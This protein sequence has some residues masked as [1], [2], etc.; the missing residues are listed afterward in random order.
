[1]AALRLTISRQE[2]TH[3][4]KRLQARTNSTAS[5]RDQNT[6]S[7]SDLPSPN[8]RCVAAYAVSAGWAEPVRSKDLDGLTMAS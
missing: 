1:M 6:T 3:P 8:W 7:G 5:E 2:E 4:K